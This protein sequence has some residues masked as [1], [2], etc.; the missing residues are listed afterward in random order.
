M[1][2]KSSKRDAGFSLIELLDALVIL[3]PIAGL[4]A[5]KCLAILAAREPTPQRSRSVISNP[6]SASSFSTRAANGPR[7]RGWI[8]A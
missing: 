8:H 5:C 1:K 2:P 6:L 4:V 7:P 3:A